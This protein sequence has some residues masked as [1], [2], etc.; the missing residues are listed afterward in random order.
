MKCGSAPKCP[1]VFTLLFGQKRHCG[2]KVF[3]N[4]KDHLTR[5]FPCLDWS[6]AEFSK[7]EPLSVDLQQYIH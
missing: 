2:M 1:C 3:L 7:K 6:R 4:I 5:R